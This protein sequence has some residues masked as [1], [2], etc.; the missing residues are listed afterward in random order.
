MLDMRHKP[1]VKAHVGQEN[2]TRTVF[3]Q[4]CLVEHLE[5]WETN[6]FWQSLKQL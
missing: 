6:T 2:I 5:R 1:K 4:K 3:L